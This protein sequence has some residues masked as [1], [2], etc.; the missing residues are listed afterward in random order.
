MK[1]IDAFRQKYDYVSSLL[2]VR[3]KYT[4]E[5]LTNSSIDSSFES[6]GLGINI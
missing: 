2:L 4:F 1:K 6:H 3:S 5:R